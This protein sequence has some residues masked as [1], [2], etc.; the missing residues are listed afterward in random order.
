VDSVRPLGK[1]QRVLVPL[2]PVPSP[3]RAV[4]VL[5][6]WRMLLLMCTAPRRCQGRA[7]GE[8]YP[9]RRGYRQKPDRDEFSRNLSILRSLRGSRQDDGRTWGGRKQKVTALSVL[10]QANQVCTYNSVKI[11]S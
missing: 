9:A 2:F 6:G 5:G 8:K 4:P 10:S 7:A 11:V 3:L 1:K